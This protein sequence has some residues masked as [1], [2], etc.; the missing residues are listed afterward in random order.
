MDYHTLKQYIEKDMQ[1]THMYQP[2]M[3]MTILESGT[4]A[5]SARD[6]A[7]SFVSRDPE[8]LDY[9][10]RIVKRWPQK[11]LRNHNIIEYDRGT[12]L[13]SIP[14]DTAITGRQRSRLIKLCHDRFQ[15][16]V[17]K[18]PAIWRNSKTVGRI[19]K[20]KRYDVMSKSKGVCAACG[21]ASTKAELDVD[22]IV[23]T[24]WGGTN[25]LDNL[26]ALCR[27]C[28]REKRDRDDTNF[29][30]WHKQLQ[31]A[32]NPKCRICCSYHASKGKNGLAFSIMNKKEYLVS[33][34]RHV[35]SYADMIPPERQLCMDLVHK[36]M[37]VL[38]TRSPD[39]EF[40]MYGLDTPEH[41][42]IRIVRQTRRA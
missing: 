41:Y 31:F 26:Q 14:F 38:K 42:H 19:T 15:Q 9:Y 10:T 12:K 11:T 30:L 6:V 37:R 25:N 28:N 35:T 20:N 13:Y 18:D 29:L 24:S 16:F 39:A 34:I 7:R 5:A 3:L 23:P 4:G 1:M 32:R 40:S 27:Q 2:L 22:H 36:T 21:R 8:Y 33:P 17:R